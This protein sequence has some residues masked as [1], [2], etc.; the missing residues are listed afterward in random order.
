[1][2][3]LRG[4]MS[5]KNITRM[6]KARIY[7]IIIRSTKHGL[8]EISKRAH[9]VTGKGKLSENFLGEKEGNGRDGEKDK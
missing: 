3:T 4:V 8:W 6:L 1:M 7:N 9:S 2:G 5:S